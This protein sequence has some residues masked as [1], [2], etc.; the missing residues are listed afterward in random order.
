MTRERLVVEP[1]GGFQAEIAPWVWALEDTRKR[2]LETVVGL[3]QEQL[4]WQ[5]ERPH[6]SIGSLL[7]HLAAIELDWLYVEVLQQDYPQESYVWFPHQVREEGGRL[8]PVAEP[9]QRHLERL[10]AVR[11]LLLEAFRGMPTDDFYRPRSLPSYDVT[12]QWVLYHLTRHEAAHQGQILQI[13][14][15]MKP[16]SG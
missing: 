13:K 6:N 4:D 9:L 14:G 2:T 16:P 7:Y 5:A 3:S 10:A 12:P 8:T 1:P 11:S 15:M